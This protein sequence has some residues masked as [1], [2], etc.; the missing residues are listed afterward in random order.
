MT[1]ATDHAGAMKK[2]VTAWHCAQSVCCTVVAKCIP[3]GQP[4]PLC[5]GKAVKRASAWWEVERVGPRGPFVI[6]VG[7]ALCADLVAS[8]CCDL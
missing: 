4:D 2:M 5:C 7:F 6:R 3:M 1:T 8:F